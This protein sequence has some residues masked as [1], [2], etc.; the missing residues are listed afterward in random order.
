MKEIIK[1]IIK[2]LLIGI[3]ILISILMIFL[4][5]AILTLEDGN[6]KYIMGRDT[7]TQLSDD[8]RYRTSRE[9]IGISL[10]DA[11]AG[12]PI[13]RGVYAY[14]KL[15]DKIY[16]YGVNGYTFI[17][18]PKTY[19]YIFR[20]REQSNERLQPHGYELTHIKNMYIYEVHTVSEMNSVLTADD[21]AVFEELFKEG[22][23][24]KE[25]FAEHYKSSDPV[26]DVIK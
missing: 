9:G 7:I 6:D 23:A 4:F 13:E 15:N 5:Y 22:A 19:L 8:A 11:A 3:A 25:R 20:N 18:I 16:V 24:E 17:D 10:D 14:K 1:K 21:R 12:G 2:Y 26:I